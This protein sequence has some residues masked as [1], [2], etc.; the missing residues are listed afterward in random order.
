VPVLKRR[1]WVL[2]SILLNHSGA[3]SLFRQLSSQIAESIRRGE[4]RQG[5][6]LPSTRLMAKLLRVSRNTVL[7]A[8]EELSADELIIGVPG[9]GMHVHSAFKPI[10]TYGTDLRPVIRAAHF[11]AKIL[12]LADPDGNPLYLNL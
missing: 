11:P 3:D 9:S 7:T 1:D 5:D 2:L 6:R 8:Y 12:S 4:I 10:G